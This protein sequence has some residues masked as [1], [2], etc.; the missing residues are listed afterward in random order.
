[1][2]FDNEKL[3][4]ASLPEPAKTMYINGYHPK[5]SGDIVVIKS[6]G[7]KNGSRM[8]ATHGDW[9]PYDAHIPLVWMGK[10]IKPGKTNRTVGMT[11][12]APTVA[13]ILRVQMPSGCIGEVITEVA[14]Q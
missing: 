10:G 3:A 14:H 6:A 11:D 4:M 7:W 13:A 2:V 9:N 12:I 8:G 1:N 5:R